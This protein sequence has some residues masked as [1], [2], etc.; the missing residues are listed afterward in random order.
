MWNQRVTHQAL[1]AMN[2]NTGRIEKEWLTFKGKSDAP[3]NSTFT[4]YV[5]PYLKKPVIT[6]QVDEV[7]GRLAGYSERI[8]KTGGATLI[9]GVH[10]ETGCRDE[11][12]QV[13]DAALQIAGKSNWDL[14]QLLRFLRVPTILGVWAVKIDNWNFDSQQPYYVSDAQLT[15]DLH[16]LLASSTVPFI[17][18]SPPADETAANLVPPDGRPVCRTPLHGFPPRLPSP[19]PSPPPL[20]A[21][22]ATSFGL[23]GE[24]SAPP[25]DPGCLKSSS[26]ALSSKSS[27]LTVWV[28]E[29]HQERSAGFKFLA[30]IQM[31][32]AGFAVFMD[33]YIAQLVESNRSIKVFVRKLGYKREIRGSV[34]FHPWYM[35]S[36]VTKV[37][38]AA[39][40][41][42]DH[43]D[44]N[45]YKTSEDEKLC[46]HSPTSKNASDS[47]KYIQMGL[48]KNL[49]VQQTP[50]QCPKSSKEFWYPSWVQEHHATPLNLK[51]NEC[52]FRASHFGYFKTRNHRL[53]EQ[54]WEEL[55]AEKHL[56]IAEHSR[57]LEK[58]INSCPHCG[59][60]LRRLL[61]R[62][63]CSLGVSCKSA[64]HLT[65]LIPDHLVLYGRSPGDRARVTRACTAASEELYVS[66]NS[67]MEK[68]GNPYVKVDFVFRM[69][70]SEGN[71]Y[72]EP[73]SS[74]DSIGTVVINKLIAT[75]S[76]SV[77]K[78]VSAPMVVK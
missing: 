59:K 45:E 46:V 33:F 9:V 6:G 16:A 62:L 5:T 52:D 74:R 75:F 2:V 10:E 77:A 78:E 24:S 57:I 42:H 49:D 30:L 4:F 69:T 53:L 12:C 37:L 36:F 3:K 21:S 66:R 28:I 72:S 58:K 29:R 32:T 65:F 70:N 48:S 20:A 34:G 61:Q 73:R 68:R 26:P 35:K 56:G 14:T 18:I 40:V 27:R 22:V 67:M 60:R 8:V 38:R 51:P 41:S 64:S 55:V 1:I 47:E 11:K 23:Q 54:H 76:P 19:P 13:D 50:H 71:N 17:N 63:D 7:V 43:I 39:R 15:G 25:T 31:G 44:S